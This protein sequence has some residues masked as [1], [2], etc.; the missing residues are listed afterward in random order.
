VLASPKFGPW[1][2]LWV[3]VCSWLVHARKVLQSRIN[4]LVVWFVWFMWIIDSLATHPSPHLGIL[5]CFCTCE[6]V[7]A[8]EHTP[9]LFSSTVST[10]GLALEFFKECE[11]VSH[12]C[13]IQRNSMRFHQYWN[14]YIFCF[15]TF[16]RKFWWLW[17]LHHYRAFCIISHVR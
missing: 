7:E 13:H 4:E 8:K 9:T 2:V 17:L 6:V 12:W 1:W 16:A 10:F 11:G 3:C 15:V 14:I 5:A